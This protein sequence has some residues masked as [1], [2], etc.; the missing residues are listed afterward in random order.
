MAARQPVTRASPRVPNP[1]ATSSPRPH[2]A[3]SVSHL[4]AGRAPSAAPH[5]PR[6]RRQRR[7][8]S[9]VDRTDALSAMAWR[10]ES[11]PRGSHHPSGARQSTSRD[12]IPRSGVKAART[13]P[14]AAAQAVDL[15]TTG[16]R[17]SA[18]H[19]PEPGAGSRAAHLQAR[20]RWLS[21][22]LAPSGR[23]DPA[24]GGQQPAGPRLAW[25]GQA[26]RSSGAPPRPDD[27]CRIGPHRGAG[28]A[29]PMTSRGPL[30]DEPA[31]PMAVASDAGSGDNGTRAT[32]SR[33][34]VAT[35]RRQALPHQRGRSALRPAQKS[36]DMGG[37]SGAWHRWSRCSNRPRVNP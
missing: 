19:T 9:C 24:R 29:W 3:R 13:D 36:P 22:S 10:P 31:G 33:E 23:S 28:P 15:P 8:P 26:T 16:T 17:S 25:P 32:A 4:A 7:L 21:G 37:S 6:D 27:G 12:T 30:T 18:S 2:A 14:E 34:R 5:P 11:R 20:R 35:H 1:L